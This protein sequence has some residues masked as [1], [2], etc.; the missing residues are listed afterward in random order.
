MS[1]KEKRKIKDEN[2]QFQKE[3]GEPVFFVQLKYKAICLICRQTITTLKS[4]NLK[5]YELKA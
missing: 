3:C 1:A 5:Q 2:R 4:C